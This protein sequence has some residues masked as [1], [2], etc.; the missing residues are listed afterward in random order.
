MSDLFNFAIDMM[1]S[2]IDKV[3]FLNIDFAKF[4]YHDLLYS[5]Q[6]ARLQDVYNRN[7]RGGNQSPL[8]LLEHQIP[9]LSLI[10]LNLTCRCCCYRFCFSNKSVGGAKEETFGMRLEREHPLK[11]RVMWYTASFTAHQVLQYGNVMKF[12]IGFS[13]CFESV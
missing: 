12:C 9:A 11:V 8:V 5:Y 6:I 10:V 13:L 3:T 7:Y 1:T 4:C 2:S